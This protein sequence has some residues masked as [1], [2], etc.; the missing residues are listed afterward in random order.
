MRGVV[1]NYDASSQF[2]YDE[3]C[4]KWFSDL[5]NA[6]FAVGPDVQED[7]AAEDFIKIWYAIDQDLDEV[8]YLD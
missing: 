6:C 1:L 5:P 8:V 2:S 4:V 3:L 7:I